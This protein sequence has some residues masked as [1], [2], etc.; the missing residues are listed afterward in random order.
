MTDCNNE[1]VA[2]LRH[3]AERLLLQYDRLSDD[4]SSL[5]ASLDVLHRAYRRIVPSWDV[6][7]IIPRF[8][9]TGE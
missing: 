7:R 1:A 6:G 3:A 5:I 8:V 4:G 2:I 9:R